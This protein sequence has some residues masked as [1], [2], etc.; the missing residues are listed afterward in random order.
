M[1]PL[2]IGLAGY[3]NW[4]RMAYVPA[5][6]ADGRGR[7]AA[8]SAPSQATR[9]RIREE[10]GSQVRIYPHFEAMLGAGNLDGVLMA[11]PEAVHEPA[12]LAAIGSGIPFFYE[13]PVSHR[14]DRILP[15][16]EKLLKAPQVHQADLELRFLPVV[17]AAAERLAQGAI[18]EPQ[19]A[20]IRMNGTWSAR[21]G[22]DLS[23]PH[24]LAPWYVDA[25]DAI[26]GSHPRR[27]LVQD[28]RGT[29]GRMQAY[30][31]TQLDY[32]GVWG[33]FQSN[34]SSVHGPETWIEVQG[35][36]G[37]LFADLFT[38]ELRIRSRSCPEWRVD[39]V[40]C[41]LRPIAG[42]P[43]LREC[44]A[45]FLD[46]LEG[47]SSS[48]APAEDMARLHCLGL[49]AEESIDSSAWASVRSMDELRQNL[50]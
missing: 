50:R 11:L 16:L 5:L 43:G 35:G 8:A 47:K 13:P 32:G 45:D 21:P 23:L 27:V 20:R 36:E 12:L 9:R 38:G 31:L 2:R 4:A 26:L 46:R 29:E 25:L 39:R 37:D 14:R 34:I 48:G 30:A 6:R 15:V 1:N 33:T 18:G 17:A 19:T 41:A 3:G 28:G 49:A 10:L 40:V 22:A 7:V 44:L 24:L 42:W